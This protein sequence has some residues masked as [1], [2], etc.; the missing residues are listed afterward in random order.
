M[1]RSLLL[2]W[3]LLF[4]PVAFASD[5]SGF[6]DSN[7]HADPVFDQ[8]AIHKNGVNIAANLDG[9]CVAQ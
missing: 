9:L 8:H 4:L 3:C 7:G 2:V 1:P 5:F 6:L